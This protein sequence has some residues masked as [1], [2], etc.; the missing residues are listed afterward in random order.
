[1]IHKIG[2]FTNYRLKESLTMAQ[3]LAGWLLNFDVKV[4]LVKETEGAKP[5]VPL[6]LADLAGDPPDMVIALGG[7]GTLLSAARAVYGLNLPILS[8]NMGN[9]GFLT[10]VDRSRIYE[11]IETVFAGNY[12]LDHRMM[13]RG[14]IEREGEII[15]EFVGLNDMVIHKGALSRLLSFNVWVQEDFMGNYKGDG[16]ILASPTGSTGYSLSAGGP[17]VYPGVEVILQT[18]ICPHTLT[19][20][21]TVIPADFQ[22]TVEVENATSQV[23]LTV[24][25]QI[26][27][28]LRKKDKIFVTKAPCKASFVRLRPLD[29]F[30][31]LRK[32]LG[33]DNQER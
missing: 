6:P 16:I 4:S 5:A 30:P 1:M 26:S 3:K 14:R 19:G 32:K 21:P 13:L 24:D 12:Q 17:V 10:E 25:G 28:S 15:R 29:F 27:C 23:L 7:D 8:V 22:C 9:L 2:L 11:D 33:D 31:I 18:L 20:R